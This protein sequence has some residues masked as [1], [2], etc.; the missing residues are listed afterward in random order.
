MEKEQRIRKL[1]DSEE[2]PLLSKNL[3]FIEDTEDD[4]KAIIRGYYERK[5][6]SL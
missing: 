6:R 3:D 2:I 4:I 5:L 1:I